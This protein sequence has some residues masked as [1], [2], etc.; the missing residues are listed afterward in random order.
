MDDNLS[1]SIFSIRSDIYDAFPAGRIRRCKYVE[2]N[3]SINPT[4]ENSERLLITTLTPVVLADHIEIQAL[5]RSVGDKS[6]TY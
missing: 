2:L 4:K 1:P 5:K 3:N 6:F